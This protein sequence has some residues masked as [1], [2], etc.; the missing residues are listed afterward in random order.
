MGVEHYLD[1][2]GYSPKEM[3]RHRM[4]RREGSTCIQ[5]FHLIAMIAVPV[6]DSV[7]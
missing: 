2:L 7:M 4:V 6:R 5:A 3:V 1:L